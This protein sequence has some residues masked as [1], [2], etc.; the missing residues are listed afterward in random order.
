MQ[1]I[2]NSRHPVL[3]LSLFAV[4]ISGGVN[5]ARAQ[6]P[7]GPTGFSLTASGDTAANATW[8]ASVTTGIESTVVVWDTSGADLIIFLEWPTQVVVFSAAG[9]P[10]SALIHPLPVNKELFLGVFVL[11]GGLWSMGKVDTSTKTITLQDQTP[12]ATV[13]N[14]NAL[15]RQPTATGNNFRTID[16]S[17]TPSAS[18]DA[19]SIIIT[20]RTDGLNPT[21]YND[22][23]A[24]RAG[25][26]NMLES[27][28]PASASSTTYYLAN[29][30]FVMYHFA[31]FVKDVAG[32]WTLAD[33]I[34]AMDTVT[35]GAARDTVAPDSVLSCS[36]WV[37]PGPEIIIR[38]YNI[39]LLGA[40]PRDADSIGIWWDLADTVNKRRYV[41]HLPAYRLADH[42]T[43][44]QAAGL[45]AAYDWN[46][47]AT[48]GAWIQAVVAMKD[49]AGN[50]SKASYSPAL[51]ISLEKN[52]ARPDPP[53]LSAEP[54]PFNPST[55]ISFTV[56]KQ[57]GVRLAIYDAKGILVQ[58][59][60]NQ[61]MGL[62]ENTVIWNATNLS[63]GIYVAR[64]VSSGL[65]L[66]RKV[67]LIK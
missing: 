14:F 26:P 6:A 32:N 36:L 66:T 46:T 43:M 17:W 8:T 59:L 58:T 41:D 51:E 47:I 56:E 25:P 42:G 45:G 63:S 29:Y 64:L 1:F 12:P 20:Y 34:N 18:P 44:V 54:N 11:K 24:Y 31:A 33:W 22:P 50:W 40:A 27:E 16:L 57:R 13:T 7:A 67:V 49:T 4:F 48:P 38:V 52:V 30:P 62:G 15:L 3:A 39:D 55:V 61:P 37:N 53:W 21:A 5:P 19:D 60:I 23:L 35:T 28:L 9:A 2:K 10:T 65:V